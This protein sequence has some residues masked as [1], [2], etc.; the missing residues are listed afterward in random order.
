[1]L[2]KVLANH[3][4]MYDN[5]MGYVDINLLKKFNNDDCK[6]V[7]SFYDKIPHL[8]DVEIDETIKLSR[9]SECVQLALITHPETTDKTINKILSSGRVY[10]SALKFLFF[11]K[12]LSQENAKLVVKLAK[13]KMIQ[14]AFE[15]YFLNND[16]LY[17]KHADPNYYIEGY[18]SKDLNEN[19]LAEI[20]CKECDNLLEAINSKKNIDDA[21]ATYLSSY[22]L[23]SFRDAP[24]K[25]IRNKLKELEE[26][27][28][29]LPEKIASHIINNKSIDEETREFFLTNSN[30]DLLFATI[31]SPN[32][33]KDIY[34]ANV[35][36]SI[37]IGRVI[38]YQRQYASGT[39]IENIIKDTNN[40]F[41]FALD[42][43]K[44]CFG[45]DYNPTRLGFGILNDLIKTTTDQD[46]L[47]ALYH[48]SK[49]AQRTND[50]L[51]CFMQNKHLPPEVSQDAINRYIEILKNNNNVSLNFE[52]VDATARCMSKSE[53]TPEQCETIYKFSNILKSTNDTFMLS[54]YYLELIYSEN[55][56]AYILEAIMNN[57]DQGISRITVSGTT[58]IKY[59]AEFNEILKQNGIEN[60][61]E[62]LASFVNGTPKSERLYDVTS[63]I[64][65]E[66]LSHLKKLEK[67]LSPENN[68]DAYKTNMF[69]RRAH[70]L[71]FDKIESE[72]T[73]I[74]R[75]QKALQLKDD[76]I[77]KTIHNE[78]QLFKLYA[79]YGK[80]ERLY[81]E[82]Q[83]LLLSF[84]KEASLKAEKK[85]SFESFEER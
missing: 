58:D 57:S 19:I 35:D 43:G 48:E 31:Y 69:L 36:N 77:W 2:N 49:S 59:I 46:L 7:Q 60:R 70:R 63:D 81:Q 51:Y 33:M 68:P 54:K 4:T 65:E 3:E 41:S 56:P 12:D 44:R 40:G 18:S 28:F 5:L 74:G 9:K 27:I 10:N 83:D 72:E 84:A 23:A 67:I 26:H 53:L 76:E 20:C 38:E 80:I 24:F 22:A 37:N 75:I 50:W 64:T 14:E 15:C 47:T 6:L 32:N 66:E 16:D 45:L 73:E 30:Y 17:D 55:T 13:P 29:I 62:V 1:M 61:K 79:D 25:S 8:T 21:N 71:V 82:K 11:K 39:I 34:D 85:Q 78:K 42:Y 52:Q